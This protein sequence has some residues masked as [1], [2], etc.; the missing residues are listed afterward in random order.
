MYLVIIELRFLKSLVQERF[1]FNMEYRYQNIVSAIK[2][3]A[4]FMIPIALFKKFLSQQFI[5]SVEGSNM[6]R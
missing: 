2:R 5:A 3:F 4:K 1:K 6:A